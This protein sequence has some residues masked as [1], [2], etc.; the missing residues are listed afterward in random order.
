MKRPEGSPDEGG[1]GKFKFDMK[2]LSFIII[3]FD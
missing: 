3:K 1:K 2:F